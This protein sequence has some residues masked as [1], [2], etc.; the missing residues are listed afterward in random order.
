M[1]RATVTIPD[2]LERAV[3]AYMRD[4][5]VPPAL[6]AVMQTALREYLTAR[7]YLA[8]GPSKAALVPSSGGKPRGLPLEKAPVI[9]GK[10]VAQTVIED[11]R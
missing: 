3:E 7:G 2:D 4:L 6:T 11:R 1:K 9:K 10:T 5:E 8:E